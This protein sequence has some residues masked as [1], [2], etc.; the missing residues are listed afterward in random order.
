MIESVLF[1]SKQ[2]L[3]GYDMHLLETK[4]GKLLSGIIRAETAADITMIDAEGKKHTVKIAD[5]ESRV[6][7]P[8]SI[9]PEGLQ[10]NLTVSEFADLISFLESLKEKMPGQPP[11]K[12]QGAQRRAVPAVPVEMMLQEVPAI[13]P[14][15]D[16]S[17]SPG[18]RADNTDQSFLP[19]A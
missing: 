17:Y 3:D 10:T 19:M 7:S 11:A 18:R 2:I 13:S 5:L 8:K 14:R 1:P 4:D 15:I 9:M 16:A 6:K 12:K